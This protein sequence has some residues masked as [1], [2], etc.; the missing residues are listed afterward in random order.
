MGFDVDKIELTL[1]PSNSPDLNLNDLGFFNALQ[2]LYY[3]SSPRNVRQLIELVQESYEEYPADRINRIWLTLQGV[4]NE[5]IKCNGGAHYKLPHMNK[6]RLERLGLLPETLE[7]CP[8]AD[9]LF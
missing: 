3:K 2:A 1:Q 8:E 9:G 7:V 6:D 5:I 4:M